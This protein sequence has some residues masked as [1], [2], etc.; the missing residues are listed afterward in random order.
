MLTCTDNI[1]IALNNN[2]LVL[3]VTVSST[4]IDVW[5][6]Q[7]VTYGPVLCVFSD[8][9]HLHEQ[10]INISFGNWI[11]ES[12]CFILPNKA[13]NLRLHIDIELLLGEM[14]EEEG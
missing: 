11:C 3:A 13:V 14:G 1:K 7:V 8:K 6:F 4:Y 12:K 10:T 9:S 2:I 5:V